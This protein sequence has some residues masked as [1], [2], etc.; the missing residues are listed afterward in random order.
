[1]SIAETGGPQIGESKLCR[2]ENEGSRS[3]VVVNGLQGMFECFTI[4]I[5]RRLALADCKS[6]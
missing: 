2:P 4:Y 1:M 6:D 3:K 5:D